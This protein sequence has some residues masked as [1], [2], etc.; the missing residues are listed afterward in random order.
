MRSIWF[1]IP[2]ILLFSCQPE[3]FSPTAMEEAL[4]VSSS[5]IFRINEPIRAME[6]LQKGELLSQVSKAEL[7]LKMEE[8]MVSLDSISQP[9]KEDVK[10]PVYAAVNLAGAD[11]YEILWISD[12]AAYGSS[13]PADFKAVKKE[14]DGTEYLSLK[15]GKWF[16]ARNKGVIGA[17]RN[18]ILV[19]EMIRQQQAGLSLM[20]EPGFVKALE[21]TNRRDPLNILIQMDEFGA[22]VKNQIPG[23]NPTY[24]ENLGTWASFDLHPEKDLWLFSGIVLFPDSS[25]KYLSTL[26]RGGTAEARSRKV[27]P[28]N[29]AAGVVISVDDLMGYY[30]AYQPFL[31]KNRLIRGYMDMLPVSM[32]EL[33]EGFLINLS[34]EWG[35]FYLEN[36]G[37]TLADNKVGFIGMDDPESTQI[38]LRTLSEQ[39]P[40]E[41]YREIP[42]QKIQNK[43]LFQGAFGRLFRGLTDPYYLIYDDFLI[44]SQNP[45][46]LKNCL[47]SLLAQRTLSE[48]AVF[49]EVEGELPSEGQLLGFARTPEALGILRDLLSKEDARQ[50]ETD[51]EEWQ[52]LEWFALRLHVEKEAAVATAIIRRKAQ[53]QQ[54]ARQLWTVELESNMIGKPHPVKN[55]YNGEIEV[56]VQ[57][58]ANRIY[59]VN[60]KGKI[61]WSRTID[62]PILGTVEQVDAYRNNKL[63]MVFSTPSSLYLVDR[64]GRDVE[65]FPTKLPHQATAGAAVFDYD[66]TRSYRVIIPAGNRLLNYSLEGK[67]VEGWNFTPTES[68]IVQTPK[69]LRVGTRD[70]I[71]AVEGS[72]KIH[73]L[74]RRGETRIKVEDHFPGLQTDLF[75]YREKPQDEPRL[76][77]LN[78]DGEMVLLYFNGKGETIDIGLSSGPASVTADGMTLI[79]L[80][81]DKLVV[82]DPDHPFDIDLTAVP[83]F[84]PIRTYGYTGYS[85][86]EDQKVFLWDEDGE[87]VE[88][89]PLYGSTG[90]CI[91][92]MAPDTGI[93][94]IIGTPERTLISY[95]IR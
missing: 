19:K 23:S 56:I 41:S 88:G 37:G 94:L 89:F 12:A 90:F 68:N 42:I 7:L 6:K 73:L 80:N 43:G 24:F 26:Y 45:L 33:K 95:K 79:T 2:L 30:N 18:E 22:F 85:S 34:G 58:E 46:T 39:D 51:R 11:K 48:D 93:D 59:L 13:Y 78:R 32:E 87:A 36:A 50:L 54:E 57:D 17:S 44:L 75:P 4:P 16:V 66:N 14:Y 86:E 25:H 9:S 38:F 47:N 82:K 10:S 61:L 1:F 3:G 27:I 35:M 52:S 65:Q 53:E 28:S 69:H 5:I 21:T 20:N 8:E 84:G 67:Q 71:L 29:A 15:D 77:G 74:N 49:D 76:I 64:L 63:Q 70:Y 92:K 91:Q 55:H 72:G 81:G 62:G 31:E 60:R 83:G 40:V